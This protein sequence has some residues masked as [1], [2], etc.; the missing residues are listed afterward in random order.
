MVEEEPAGGMMGSE[1]HASVKSLTL[2]M[3]MTGYKQVA[4][5]LWPLKSG[6]GYYARA[7]VQLHDFRLKASYWTCHDFMTIFGNPFYGAIS[8]KEE[9]VGYKR[10]HVVYLGAEYV[11][12]LGKGFALGIEADL[13]QHFPGQ[14][15][16]V[17]DHIALNDTPDFS[18]GV[19]LRINPSFLIK[20]F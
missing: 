5:D 11:K 6:Y 15:S 9:G 14:Q 18:A 16:Y 12:Q 4:G 19:Y 8:M 7:A 1:P 13:Y 3:A 17:P 20:Q 10:P 2:E